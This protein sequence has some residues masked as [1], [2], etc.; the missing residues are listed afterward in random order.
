[1]NEGEVYLFESL[2]ASCESDD[3]QHGTDYV[4]CNASTHGKC[5]VE[6]CQATQAYISHYV[7][8]ALLFLLL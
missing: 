4:T 2:Q 3:T 5:C 7:S 6:I 8:I 1:M